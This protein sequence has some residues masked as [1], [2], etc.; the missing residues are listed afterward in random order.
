MKKSILCA[1]FAGMA[2]LTASALSFSRAPAEREVAPTFVTVGLVKGLTLENAMTS[3]L[4]NKV[5]KYNFMLYV[6]ELSHIGRKPNEGA[7]VRYLCTDTTFFVRVDLTDSDV[8]TIATKNQDHHY[9]LGDVLEVFIK[10]KKDR[11][12]W[13]IYGV[14]NKLYTRFYFPSKGT[15]GLPSGFEPTDVKIGVDAKV[16]GTFNK[17]DDRDKGWTVIIAIPRNELE[18]NGYKFAP[19][20]DWTVLAARYNY[21]VH[22]PTHELSAYP[23]IPGSYHATDYY[24]NIK[25]ENINME[26]N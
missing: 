25:F 4:W 9:I 13:E 10:P 8:M 17:H 26:E 3:D 2:V 23:Q 14:P 18:K 5:P 21:S 15:L 12:Y 7:A 22:L 19:G 24:A 1:F 6:T 11:Y 16:Y 20:N